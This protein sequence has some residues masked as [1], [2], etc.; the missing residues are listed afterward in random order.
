MLLFTFASVLAP[1][2]ALSFTAPIGTMSS[3]QTLRTLVN[4]GAIVPTHIVIRSVVTSAVIKS[5]TQL[6]TFLV[7]DPLDAVVIGAVNGVTLVVVPW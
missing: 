3:F 1:A 2:F 4:L 7:Q 6:V 5:I